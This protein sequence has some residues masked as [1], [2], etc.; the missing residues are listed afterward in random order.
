MPLP[1]AHRRSRNPDRDAAIC[2]AIGRGDTIREVAARY[3]LCYQ[4]VHQIF[5]KNER[6]KRFKERRRELGLG[7]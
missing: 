2:E 7:T 5:S 3:G 1:L 6:A 4:R